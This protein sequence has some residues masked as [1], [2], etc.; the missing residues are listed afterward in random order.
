MEDQYLYLGLVLVSLLVVLASRRRAAA[1]G[2]DG[3]RLPPSPW[4]LPVIGHLHHL[5]GALPHHAMRALSRRHG[6]VM[7]L[8]LG[9]VQTL[10]LTSREAAR[11]VMKTHDTVFA[12][13]RLSA[14]TRLLTNGGRDLVNAPYGEHWRQLRKIA[15]TELLTVRRVLSFRGIRE[16]EVSA[17]L[18]EVADAAAKARPVEMR[19][20]LSALVAE[21]LVRAVMGV[22]CKDLDVLLSKLERALELSGGFHPADLWPSSRI[23]CGL[24]RALRDAQE[25]QDM[26][27]VVLEGIIQEHLAKT[28]DGHAEDLLD[29]LLKIQREGGLRFPLDTDVIKFLVFELFGAGSE[30]AFTTLEWAVAELIKNP[31]AMQRATADVRRAFA[32]SGTVVEERLGEVPYLHLVMQETLR[33]HPPVPLLIPRESREAC[34]VLGYD[35]PQGTQV[36][37]NVWALG[38]D[39]RYWDAPEEFRPERFEHE[40]AAMDFKGADFELL[41]FGGGRRICPGMAFGTAIVE[42]ALASLMLHFDW[43]LDQPGPGVVDPAQLDMTE[44]F[45][46][47]ARRKANLWLR[48]VLRVP[49]PGV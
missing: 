48:P 39:E 49:I 46:L 44:T 6:P 27:F 14:T 2:V 31:K 42:Y 37:V 23:A 19:A 40:A 24:S 28:G 18:H 22:R 36:L 33:L 34:Q 13:R 41:P 1:H 7:L 21:T 15:V 25:C 3:L 4:A 43:E 8:R 47:T 30:S 32:A 12:S 29:V 26:V 16:E 45:G 9:E 11:E 17:M 35:V 20:R 5:V 10:V 38:R